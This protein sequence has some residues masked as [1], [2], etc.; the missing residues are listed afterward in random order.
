M[1]IL[2]LVD[3]LEECITNYSELNIIAETGQEVYRVH[4]SGDK[5]PELFSMHFKELIYS[6]IDSR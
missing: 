1:D 4:T 2:H 3:R 6:V 5:A